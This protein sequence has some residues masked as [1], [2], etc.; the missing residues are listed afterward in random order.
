MSSL[1]NTVALI[2]GASRGIG[3]SI[4]LALAEAGAEI[5]V[6]YRQNAHLADDLCNEIRKLKRR[7]IPSKLMYL[8]PAMLT[9]WSPQLK[10]N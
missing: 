1:A 2:T 6:N 7:A 5:A 10:K 8:F 9:A 3:K 4:A